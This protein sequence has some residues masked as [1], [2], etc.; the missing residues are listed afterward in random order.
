MNTKRRATNS[1]SL[2]K[3]FLI[4]TEGTKTE[5]EYFEMLN[6]IFRDAN[7]KCPRSKPS[8]N[9]PRAVLRQMEREIEKLEFL[10]TDQAWIVT[11]KNEWSEEQLNEPYQWSTECENFGF[12]VSNPNFE[13]WLLLHFDDGSDIN[14]VKD[15]NEKLKSYIPTY[16]KSIDSSIFLKSNVENAVRRAKEKDVP[17]CIDWPKSIGKTTVYKLVKQI[18]ETSKQ[19]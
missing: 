1:K 9:N 5:P 12:A 13:Y 15:V 8:Q 19:S 16:N 4:C 2:K 7:I 18:I 14:E 11:D 3:T 17:P 10:N 6:S